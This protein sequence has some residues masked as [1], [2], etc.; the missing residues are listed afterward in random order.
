MSET[1]ILEGI[2]VVARAHLGVT[3]PIAR[4]TPLIEALRLDSIRLVTL[5]AEIENHFRICLEDGDEVG[6]VT[7]GD[8]AALIEKRLHG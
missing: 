5:I 2:A 3:E 4:E 7:V 1:E 6:L 8:L